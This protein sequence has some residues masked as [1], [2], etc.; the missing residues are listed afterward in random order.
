M[1]LCQIFLVYFTEVGMRGET[2]V[3]DSQRDFLLAG[4]W[5][6][7]ETNSHGDVRE[8][9]S[10]QK[11]ITGVEARAGQG[12]QQQVLRWR[13]GMSAWPGGGKS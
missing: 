8:R 6:E 5:K 3:S 12:W 11:E 13:V 2:C 4:L 7:Q 9:Q 1:A 10:S